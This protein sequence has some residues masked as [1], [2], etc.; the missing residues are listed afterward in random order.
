MILVQ[1]VAIVFQD[2]FWLIFVVCRLLFLKKVKIFRVNFGQ[3]A[4]TC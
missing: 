1:Y 3:E 2:D 4:I